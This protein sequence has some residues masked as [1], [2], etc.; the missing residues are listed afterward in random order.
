MGVVYK[1]EDTQLGRHVALKFLSE[2]LAH[3]RQALEKDRKLRYQSAS[4]M[5]VDLQRLKR[6]S[7][8]KR[9]VAVTAAAPQ[10][11]RR[12]RMPNAIGSARH[13]RMPAG[14][15]P[16]QRELSA[17]TGRACINASEPSV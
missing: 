15:Y 4:E 17:L 10:K 3:D 1:A 6:D 12:A 16:Q 2:T 11:K 8:S 7:D 14:I 5:K 9:L 13:L